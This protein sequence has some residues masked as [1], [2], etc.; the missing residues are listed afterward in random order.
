MSIGTSRADINCTR[1]LEEAAKRNPSSVGFYTQ[2]YA[3]PC[4]GGCSIPLLEGADKK[5]SLKGGGVVTFLGKKV[6]LGTKLLHIRYQKETRKIYFPFP[7]QD[8]TSN[9]FYYLFFIL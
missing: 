2:S 6:S 3:Q 4:H 9:F 1:D 8:L 7:Y 5:S